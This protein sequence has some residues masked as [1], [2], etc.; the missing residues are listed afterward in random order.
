MTLSSQFIIDQLV[1][2]PMESDTPPTKIS[3]QQFDTWHHQQIFATLR[4]TRYGRD[5]CE[6]FCVFDNILWFDDRPDNCK[7][8]ILKHYVVR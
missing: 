8:Y 4:G 2:R 5:F 1:Q 7:Q 3:R 6:T